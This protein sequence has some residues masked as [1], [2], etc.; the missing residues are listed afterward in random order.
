[1]KTENTPNELTADLF[2]LHKDIR[3]AIQEIDTVDFE[4]RSE[5]IEKCFLISKEYTS[6][7]LQEANKEI[8]RLKR[9]ISLE[10]N[11][12]VILSKQLKSKDELL[13]K[14][15][16]SIQALIDNYELGFGVRIEKINDLLTQYK[17]G[18]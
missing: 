12:N 1:M 2:Q 10:H 5:I 15:A 16:A 7:K 14:M 6:L 8:E 3:H 18:K 13:E 17:K 11:E 9:A 4:K